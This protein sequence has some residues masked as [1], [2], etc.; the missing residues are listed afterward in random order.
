[1]KSKIALCPILC[2]LFVWL[3]PQTSYGC[4]T[5]CLGD[6]GELVFGRNYDWNVDNGLVIVNKRGVS[7]TAMARDLPAQWTSEFGSVTFNQFGRELPLGGMNEEGLVVEVMWLDETEYPQ[8]DSRPALDNLQWVQYQLDNFTTVDEVIGSDSAV[9]ISPGSGAKVHYLVSD[10]K[11]D[12][13]S[14]EFLDGKLVYH[15]AETMV[16]KTLTN[17]TYTESIEFLKKHEGFG[18]ESPIPEGTGSLERF[19]RAAKLVGEYEPGTAQSA[20][21][22]AFGILNDVAQG[23][24]TKWSIVYDV[25]NFRI[26]FRTFANRQI[27]HID[28]DSL[29]FSCAT[30]VKILDMNADLTGSVTQMF[31]DYTY[32]INSALIRHVFGEVEFLKEVPDEVLNIISRYPESTQCTE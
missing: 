19:T 24:W 16:C 30:E 18:G 15:T 17:S 13:A 12:C 25:E 11:G 26:Y 8:P 20:I 7:K 2:T 3:V 6:S 23:E 4:T 29:D 27:R 14:I 5:F 28:L 21:D 1:M 31:T 22:Y 32:E 9:R 10:R